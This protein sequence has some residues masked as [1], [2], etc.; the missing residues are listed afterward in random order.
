MIPHASRI[1]PLPM[2]PPTHNMHPRQLTAIVSYYG[3]HW[4]KTE[5]AFFFVLLFLIFLIKEF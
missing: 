1:I 3:F 4:V 2:P 5:S